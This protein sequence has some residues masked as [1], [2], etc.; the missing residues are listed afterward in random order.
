MAGV[1]HAQAAILNGRDDV[2]AL[3]LGGFVMGLVGNDR[4]AAQPPF[5]AAS[6]L[7]PSSAFAYLFGSVVLATRGEANLGIECA[8]SALRLSPMDAA[9]FGPYFAIT[10]GR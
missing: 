5:D 3:A 6:S 9:N 2:N 4:D 7:S 10:L 1:R 8:E